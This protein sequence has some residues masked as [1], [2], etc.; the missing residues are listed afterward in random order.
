MDAAVELERLE[1]TPHQHPPSLLP[2]A[3]RQI[4]R[5]M[6]RG[7]GYP[8]AGGVGRKVLWK[9]LEEREESC[10]FAAENRKSKI[11][12]FFCFAKSKKMYFC[13]IETL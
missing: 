12:S 4:F 7:F 2:V 13:E 6:R 9:V 1:E 3:F 11:F 5:E 8:L 10:I